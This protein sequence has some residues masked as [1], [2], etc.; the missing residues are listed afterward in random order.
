MTNTSFELQKSKMVLFQKKPRLINQNNPSTPQDRLAAL[1]LYIRAP[2]V[3]LPVIVLYLRAS[4]FQQKHGATHG[5]KKA[6]SEHALV[7]RGW[8]F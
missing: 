7:I 5:L 3:R 4:R 8:G 2:L 1:A 6:D